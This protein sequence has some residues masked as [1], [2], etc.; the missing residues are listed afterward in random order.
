MP[1]LWFSIF[2][3]PI[4]FDHQK[5]KFINNSKLNN[6]FKE[7]ILSKDT[8][9][10]N[11]KDIKPNISKKEY[12][13]N[14][15][16]IKKEIEEGNT[17]QVNYTFK[18]KFKFS[19][20]PLKLFYDLSFKQS[21]PYAS[22][23]NFKNF[24]ILSFSPEL[25]FKKQKNKIYTKP[26]KGTISRGKNLEED[27]ENKQKL[28]KSIKDKAENIM[29]VD[30]LRN[31]LAKV[32]SIGTVEVKNLFNIEKFE[33]L[34]QMT[35]EIICKLKNK[36]DWYTIFQNLFPSGSVTGAP[37]INTMDIIKKIEKEP[38]F[39]YTGSIGHILP[40]NKAKFNVAIRTLLLNTKK[41][42]GE[43]GIGSG[44]VYDSDANKEYNEC[45]LKSKFLTDKKTN[46][47]LIE[48]ILLENTEYF[49]LEL[50]LDRLKKSAQYFNYLFK[51]S[52]IRKKLDSFRKKMQKNK[53]F[54]IR[55]MLKQNGQIKIDY[56]E[57]QNIKK[58]KTLK[59]KFSKITTNSNNIFYYHKTTNR[60]IYD[61][62]FKKAQQEGFF[63]VIFTN[64][65]NE[66][67]EGAIS[68]IVIKKNNTYFTPAI[69]SGLLNGV[70][71]QYLL[72]KKDFPLEEKILFKKD[73]YNA[74]KIYIIN[75]VRKMV[76][77]NLI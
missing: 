11:I 14:I 3:K 15:K 76:E 62:E 30:L 42:K 70:Y 64:K 36:I 63:D 69:K 5:K 50:H 32:S 51:E 1:L 2:K 22:I 48:T 29:I 39:I 28:K 4:I 38:R 55:L 43:M 72:N 75:S 12:I 13:K 41:H 27:E 37:K 67:T 77:V 66:I 58:N 25:F 10:Y 21:V 61:N 60:K 31:D 8:I 23:I 19:G 40:K 45:L 49:L 59:I 68:N 54:K 52:Y 34:F 35:S 6:L 47:S 24:Y 57:I 44:I 9:K 46:F 33:T 26:M 73:I 53:K 71:R 7:F 56:Y 16:K 65:K 20:D 74:E 17:Y 18:H